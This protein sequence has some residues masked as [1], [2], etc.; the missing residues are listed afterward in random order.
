MEFRDGGQH[1]KA[2][3][4]FRQA[5]SVSS[6][7]LQ[8]Q[9]NIALTYAAQGQLEQAIAEFEKALTIDDED[10]ASRPGLCDAHLALG[11]A[12]MKRGRAKEAVL[13][14]QRVLAIN[15]EHLE[16]RGRMAELS[17]QRAEKALTDGKDE[18]A[19]SAFAEALKFTPEDR[20]ADRARGKGAGGEK[21]QG[22]GR[23]RSPGP[24]RK[25]TRDNWDKAIEALNAALE[26]APGDE[27]ILKRI[28][29]IKE[30]QLRE[31]LDCHP[32]K[33][34]SGRESGALGYGHRRAAANTSS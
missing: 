4:F 27:S 6:D 1:E 33:S 18:E 15:A 9:V 2:I 24:R 26:I 13:S 8:A 31:R 23:T 11:D 34:G 32:V 19:L 16:A 14:Y 28:E 20:V 17:R 7:N 22:I 3:E 21:C 12:A 25:R 30:K 10:V 29:G 5:L